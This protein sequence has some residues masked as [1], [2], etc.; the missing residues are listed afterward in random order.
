MACF[1]NK[2]SNI[3]IVCST[4]SLSPLL[5]GDSD[6][7]TNLENQDLIAVISQVQQAW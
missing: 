5:P 7:E 2:L 4:K 6:H 1:Y 3:I